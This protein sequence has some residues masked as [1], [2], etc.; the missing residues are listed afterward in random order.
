MLDECGGVQW[1]WADGEQKTSNVQHRTSNIEGSE[2]ALAPPRVAPTEPHM[3]GKEG[4]AAAH[5]SGWQVDGSDTVGSRPETERRLFADGRFFHADERAKFLFD[6]P[7][8]MPEQTDTEF[9]LLLLTGRGTS[10]QWHTQT[11]TGKSDVL[12]KLYPANA[13]IEISPA[14]AEERE[15]EPGSTLWVCSRRAEIAAVA[16]VTNTVQ[17]GQVFMPMH[18]AEVN[19]LTFP[20]FDPHSR[21]PSYKAC[22]VNV[23]ATAQA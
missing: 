5:P 4:V 11:R 17:A 2:A 15:I 16:F 13:Y 8:P 10:S 21:Q 7:R 3:A 1:P 22:A 12:R 14:D 6:E 23:R 9:P 18:Y 20:S 19:Q